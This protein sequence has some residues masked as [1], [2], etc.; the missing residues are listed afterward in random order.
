MSR[1]LAAAGARAVL[2][3]I[4]DS[5]RATAGVASVGM[6]STAIIT[7]ASRGLGLA[8]ARALA[9]RGWRLVIDAR[10]A[11]ALEAARARAGRA[12]RRDALAGD[13]ADER[14]RRARSSPPPAT[15][16]T[17]SS[18]TRA[19]SA[20]ARCRR[21]PTTRSTCSSA[22][23]RSTSLAPLALIQLALP[24]HARRRADRQRHLRRR[25][26]GLRGLG[27]LRRLEG[28]ARAARRA[29]SPPSTR[30]C[31]STPSTRAT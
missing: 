1:D 27:R 28:G 12:H 16:S 9:A 30:R 21:W 25:R 15:A 13:V 7:G 18:T 26:R 3:P 10:G 17:C 31:A 24:A 8:L 14:H 5:R 2:G 11:D 6:A 19:C 22:S 20:R 29:S 4:P 23:T